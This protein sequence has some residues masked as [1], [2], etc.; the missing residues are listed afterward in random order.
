M[1][2]LI[3]AESEYKNTFL[4]GET[5][6][7]EPGALSAPETLWTMERNARPPVV[8]HGG[9][10]CADDINS[11]VKDLLGLA[12]TRWEY[13]VRVC[14]LLFRPLLRLFPVKLDDIAVG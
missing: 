1:G 11:L 9:E 3:P 12:V 5:Y 10:S 2:K 6:A 14:L 13:D 7:E 4:G 8:L